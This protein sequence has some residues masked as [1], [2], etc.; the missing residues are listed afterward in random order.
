MEKKLRESIFVGQLHKASKFC[1]LKAGTSVT[2]LR[3]CPVQSRFVT[4]APDALIPIP[5]KL[6]I[7]EAA[8]TVSTFVP[9][10]GLLHHGRLHRSRRFSS[11]SLKGLDILVTGGG[12]DEADAVINLALLGGADRIFVSQSKCSLATVHARSVRVE[13]ISD[14]PKEWKHI[15]HRYV[16][17]IVD[18]EYPKNFES[19]YGTLKSTGRLVCRKPTGRGGWLAPIMDAANDFSLLNYP[20]A[21]M[22]D[23]DEQI[24]YE[25]GDLVVS[26]TLFVLKLVCQEEYANLS[27]VYLQR[28]VRFLFELLQDRKI[29]PKV[30]RYVTL[31]DVERI[32]KR[33]R[34]HPGSGAV[35]CEPWREYTD[36]VLV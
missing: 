11:S 31:Q 24:E 16:D 30:D 25:H 18:L 34:T 2:S 3:R 22:Y 29:R 32:R 33:M 27:I 17:L 28:D 20:N 23:I 14:D 36:Q 1:P 12:T 19:L 21:S 8:A 7:G 35:V 9:A 15:I 5:E 10:M 4:L 13:L 6:D 26:K